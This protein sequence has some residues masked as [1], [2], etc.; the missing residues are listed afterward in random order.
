MPLLPRVARAALHFW[1]EPVIS[2]KNGSGTI[3]FS[4]CSL[5][6]IYCQNFEVSRGIAGKEI[7]VN[8]LAKIFSELE[9]KGAHNINLVTPTHYALAIKEAL[10]IYRPKI[11]ICYNSGGYES[12]QTLKMLEGYIDIFL[13]DFKYL[14]E[15]KAKEYSNAPDYPNI[16]KAAI[17]ECYRQQPECVIEDGIMKKGLIVRHLVLPLSTN[18]AIGIFD[19]VK[20]N[21]PNAFF[22]LM[23]Q[24]LPFGDA[25]NHPVLNRKITKREYEKVLNHICDF[26]FSNVFIQERGSADEQFIPPF[27]LC[28]V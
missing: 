23:S 25:K 27:N 4:G 7:T 9:Q 3:F 6:C 2:G 28:G 16:A 17:L 1:E 15:N 24:Y 12:T 10:D 20:D 14:S 21:A 26:N 13:L 22:S 18:D 19:W 8:R 5:S 11:P